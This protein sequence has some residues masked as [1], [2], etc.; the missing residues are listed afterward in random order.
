[1]KSL[2]ILLFSFTLSS[3]G[4]S[5]ATAENTTDPEKKVVLVKNKSETVKKSNSFEGVNQLNSRLKKQLLLPA[6]VAQ[7]GLEGIVLVNVNLDSKGN[8]KKVKVV[9]GLHKEVDK[10]IIE[11]IQKVKQVD[12]I[13][14][15]G[16]AVPKTIQLSVVVE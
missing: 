12:P 1:M 8:I 13:I 11:A 2:F 5:Q 16:K 10:T 9:E 3:I 6:I 15:R 7:E 14:I 4:I